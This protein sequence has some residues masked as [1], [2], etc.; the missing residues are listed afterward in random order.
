[1]IQLTQEQ[2][3]LLQLIE[4]L[5]RKLLPTYTDGPTEENNQRRGDYL[6]I[7]LICDCEGTE[8]VDGYTALGPNQVGFVQKVSS[9]PTIE[10]DDETASSLA[11]FVRHLAQVLMARTNH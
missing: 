5:R 9:N 1:V 6:F 7:A 4:E 10:L 11:A 8:K 2:E 3:V